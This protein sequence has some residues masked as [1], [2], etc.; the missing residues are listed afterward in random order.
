MLNLKN[1]LAV[2]VRPDAP[3][4]MKKLKFKIIEVNFENSVTFYVKIK[5]WY[6]WVYEKE[7]Y[8]YYKSIDVYQPIE[9]KSEKSIIEYFKKKFKNK[10]IELI[11][12]ATYKV[13]KLWQ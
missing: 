1:E 13:Y 2:Q 5:K 12:K 11:Q 8:G 7:I 10:K 3:N 9:F 6:G 4:N